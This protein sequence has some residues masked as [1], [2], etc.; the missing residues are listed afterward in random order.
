MDQSPNSGDS[1]AGR[2][3]NYRTERIMSASVV[4]P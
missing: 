2:K 1:S 3:E 4:R